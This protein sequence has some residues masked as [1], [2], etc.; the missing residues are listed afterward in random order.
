MLNKETV[1][2][3][4]HPDSSK[5]AFAVFTGIP[6]ISSDKVGGVIFD[7][8]GTLIDSMWLWME[9]DVE[10]LGRYGIPYV[11]GLQ[12][13]IEGK[14]FKETA[15]YFKE[16]FKIPETIEYMMDE[17]NHMAYDKYN[18]E[19]FLKEGVYDF[20]LKLKK[21]N[22]PIGIAT[23]NSRILVNTVLKR[24][25][26]IDFF[27][28]IVTADEVEN[29]KPAP[30][31]YLAGAK[32]L[33]A[34]PKDCLVF[35]DILKGVMAGKAAGMKVC[36]VYDEYAAYVDEMKDLSDYYIHSFKELLP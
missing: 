28:A 3:K 1:N 19:V 11:E 5:M 26:V 36:A 9:I 4:K 7:M 25:N 13:K 31:V 29:G 30:D 2:D 17:W 10:F 18:N 15:I 33:G 16:E 27:D 6:D 21:E 20:L 14:S 35:E 22:I 32:A 34:N 23:S 24:L 12:Q 8:D